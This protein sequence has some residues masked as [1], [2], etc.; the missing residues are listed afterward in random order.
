M[1]TQAFIFA[2]LL[3]TQS[4]A[5]DLCRQK[6]HCDEGKVCDIP[7]GSE[8]GICSSSYTVEGGEICYP[9]TDVCE[10]GYECKE[11]YDQG[12]SACVLLTDYN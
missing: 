5:G 3:C 12:Y 1:K 7:E 9:E 11:I 8:F 6:H 4:F 10:S 2:F